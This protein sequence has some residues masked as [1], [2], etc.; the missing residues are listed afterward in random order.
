MATGKQ[1]EAGGANTADPCG[2]RTTGYR[3]RSIPLEGS[4]PP[5]TGSRLFCFDTEQYGRTRG[6]DGK[7]DAR[8]PAGELEKR[9][10]M[11]WRTRV[12]D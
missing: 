4:D 2:D 1:Q 6:E 9:C 11:D 10:D 7:D 3:R 8:I 5:G 12:A